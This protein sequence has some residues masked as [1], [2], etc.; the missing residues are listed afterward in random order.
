MTK[1]TNTAKSTI[2][3]RFAIAG[4]VA[5]TAGAAKAAPPDPIIRTIERFR[6]AEEALSDAVKEAGDLPREQ[7]L[8]PAYDHAKSNVDGSYAF[9]KKAQLDLLTT[10]PTTRAGMASLLMRL[11]QSS[12]PERSISD[13]EP[14]LLVDAMCWGDEPTRM[15]ACTALSRIAALVLK[16]D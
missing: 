3:R 7:W 12:H 16:I 5:I 10:M 6:L 4:I 8:T 14:N 1:R 2:S 9:F 11:G 13:V 15:A